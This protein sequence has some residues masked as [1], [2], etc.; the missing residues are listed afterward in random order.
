MQASHGSKAYCDIE[1]RTLA[2]NP[3]PRRFRSYILL[4]N[5]K[6]QLANLNVQLVNSPNSTDGPRI[7]LLHITYPRPKWHFDGK[8]YNPANASPLINTSAACLVDYQ[9]HTARRNH[10]TNMREALS[11]SI[12]RQDTCSSTTKSHFELVKPYKANTSSNLSLT[13]TVSNSSISTLITCR[14]T[15]KN[16][17]TISSCKTRPSRSVESELIIKMELPNATSTRSLPGLVP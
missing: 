11:S 13:N 14:S 5:E 7:T 8:T 6:R 3:Y 9:P 12:T 15:A 16:F 2:T 1:N 10:E 17:E 4:L